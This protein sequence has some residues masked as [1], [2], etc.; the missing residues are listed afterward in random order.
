MNMGKNKVKLNRE[1]EKN[2]AS[3]RADLCPMC[4]SEIYS[5]LMTT[6]S[7]EYLVMSFYCSS[8]NE[9]F[10]I[11]HFKIYPDMVIDPVRDD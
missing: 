1:W 11:G 10:D 9:C 6:E 3:N 8:G 5:A 2:H 7:D 4:G